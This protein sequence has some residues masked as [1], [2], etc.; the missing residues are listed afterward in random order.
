MERYGVDHPTKIPGN[1]EK[2][3]ATILDR[4]GVTSI[5][6]HPEFLQK[7]KDTLMKNWGT[8]NPMHSPDIQE[9]QRQ[10]LLTNYGVSNPSKNPD[11]V[12]KMK[13]TSMERYGFENPS[14]SPEIKKKMIVASLDV[15]GISK[16]ELDVK[17]YVL[18]VLG[19]YCEKGYIGG[20]NPKELDIVI[21]EQNIAIEFNGAYWHSELFPKKGRK[22][23]FDKWQA[24]KDKGIDLIQIFDFEWENRP[25]QVKSFLRAKLKQNQH[26]I[27][28]RKCIIKEVPSKEA[29]DFIEEYHIQGKCSSSKY[30]GLYYE[31]VLY[32][33]VGIKS[34]HRNNKE[35]QISRY[36]VKNNYTITGGLTRLCKHASSVHGPLITW[37]D[38]RFSNGD[39][40]I[41][42]GWEI[43]HQLAPDYFYI[44][45]KRRKIVSKQSR[46]KSTVGTPDGM[47]EVEHAKLEGLYRIWDVG[48]IKLRFE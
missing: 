31:D 4:Y 22:Y 23:H 11:I 20:A 26:V 5:L 15:R 13:A 7:S 42:H 44:D 34:H 35:T 46:M 43:V 16:G 18:D 19:V 37:C 2:V 12:N 36:C 1:K 33:V 48:K 47:T 40:W 24:C 9:K 14:Q 29:R 8:E 6:K 10:T 28:A 45:V 32:A 38:L 27:G 17:N 39:N 41:K 25:Y 30:Y 21:K 3:A